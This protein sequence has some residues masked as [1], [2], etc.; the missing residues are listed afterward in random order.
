MDTTNIDWNKPM[1]LSVTKSKSERRTL[2]QRLR[3]ELRFFISSLDEKP[4]LTKSEAQNIRGRLN[5]LG[6]YYED[7]EED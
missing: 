3:T 4:I 7:F 1:N 2:N 5:S 6:Y